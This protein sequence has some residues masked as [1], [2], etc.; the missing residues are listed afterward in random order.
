LDFRDKRLRTSLHLEK[1]GKSIVIDTGP[2]FRMQMLRE[3]VSRLD[4]V[5]FT[6]EHKD[7][8]AGLDDI[9]PF[10]FSQQTD[11]PLFG[12]PQVLNQI[13]TE[14]SYVFAKN[15]Y[16]GVPR[17]LINEIGNLPFEVLGIPFIPIQ[18]MH[19]KLPVLGFRI[20]DF[21]YITDANYIAPEEIEK[22]KGTKTLVINALQIQPH[23]SHF[24]LDEAL[25]FIKKIEPETAYL[26]HVSHRMGM[27]QRVQQGLPDNVNLAYDGLTIHP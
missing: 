21:T 24:T 16:P 26:T 9:R 25:S 2:D 3:D 15:K 17:V 13:K 7:H 14:F 8:T 22:I 18:V 10:N 5:V 4:A 1:D 27:H 23:I 20:D 19:H 11:I 12:T 6:H